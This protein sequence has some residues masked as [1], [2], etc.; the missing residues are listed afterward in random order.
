VQFVAQTG[1]CIG[2]AIEQAR[3]AI[4]GIEGPS[5]RRVQA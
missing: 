5:R 1:W 2:E 4:R 3:A